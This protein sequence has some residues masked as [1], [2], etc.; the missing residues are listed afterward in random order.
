MKIDEFNALPAAAATSL[1]TVW[2]DVPSWASALVAGRPYASADALR[3]AAVDGPVWNTAEVD[4]ALSHHPRIGERADRDRP[5]AADSARE[6]A[7][8]STASDVVAA[9]I[10]AGN[11]AYE[12]RF[13]RV[14]LIRAA[15]RS[16]RRSSTSSSRASTTMQR[17]RRRSSRSSCGRSPRCAWSRR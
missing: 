16:P 1:V 6:Q 10:A 11:A 4:A 13:G 14:F 8:M 2:A 7:S 12:A 5:G 17:P 3:Q 9:A 15:G